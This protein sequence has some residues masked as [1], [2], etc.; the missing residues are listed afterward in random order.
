MNF[1]MKQLSVAF[2]IVCLAFFWSYTKMYYYKNKNQKFVSEISQLK[3]RI[4]SLGSEIFVLEVKLF[5][6]EEAYEIFKEKN[7][8]AS[9]QFGDIISDE[10]E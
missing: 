10:T 2:V 7:P 8:T 3:K 5:R 6:H 9:S 4:D 1:T